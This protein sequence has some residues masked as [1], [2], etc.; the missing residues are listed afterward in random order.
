MALQISTCL[1][2]LN[3]PF[4]TY[5]PVKK[6]ANSISY[7]IPHLLICAVL[8]RF[9]WVQ[10]FETLWTI[11]CQAPPSIGFSRQEYWSGL[12]SSSR[13]SWPRDRTCVF[14]VSCIGRR[15]LYHWATWEALLFWMKF[16]TQAGDRR[17]WVPKFCLKIPMQWAAFQN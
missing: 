4:L 14:W 8:N 1:Q 15:I 13:F 2:I 5:F 7:M 10:L 11:A 12:P 3:A 17:R 9:S 16:I 6:E